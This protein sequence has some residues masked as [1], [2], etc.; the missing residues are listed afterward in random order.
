M[1]KQRR[2]LPDAPG[3][4]LFRDSKRKVL[5]VGKARSIR[6]RVAGHVHVAH[7]L[8][9]WPLRPQL[10]FTPPFL[11]ATLALVAVLPFA[12]SA[13]SSVISYPIRPILITPP[14]TTTDGS[15]QTPIDIRTIAKRTVDS[16]VNSF[17][18]RWS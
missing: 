13:A 5:Y 3:V 9:Q 14:S 11:A 10:A 18:A 16:R 1:T 2:A 17:L 4:Y 12:V 7:T 8:R 6:K 15:N